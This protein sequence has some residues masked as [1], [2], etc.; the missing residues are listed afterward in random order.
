M[1]KM[2]DMHVDSVIVRINLT[3]GGISVSEFSGDDRAKFVKVLVPIIYKYALL[4]ACICFSIEYN[5]IITLKTSA[6]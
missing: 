4:R 2:T 3:S 5:D 6:N 1:L